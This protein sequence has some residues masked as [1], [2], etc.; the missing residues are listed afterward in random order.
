MDRTQV[1]IRCHPKGV[2][3]VGLTVSDLDPRSVR[4][5][6]SVHGCF[7]LSDCVGHMAQHS[8]HAPIDGV[9]GS[10]Q[11]DAPSS[12]AH[13]DFL[14]SSTRV[15]VCGRVVVDVPHVKLLT[16]SIDLPQHAACSAANPHA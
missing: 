8:W 14:N 4:D 16:S 3:C 13:H 15:A 5:M 1:C 12:K 11:V 7:C 2:S 9:V 10:L 6:W